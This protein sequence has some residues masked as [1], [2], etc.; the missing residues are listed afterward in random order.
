MQKNQPALRAKSRLLH[1][2]AVMSLGLILAASCKPKADRSMAGY[3][4]GANNDI[5]PADK[6]RASGSSI[7]DRVAHAAVLI[8][9]HL[10]EGKVKFCSGTLIAPEMASS[11]PRIL[12]NHHCFAITDSKGLA[13]ES[14]L[15]E[16]CV[17]TTIYFGVGTVAPGGELLKNSCAKGTL[18]THFG[19]DLA[20][21]NLTSAA[22]EG[23]SP[24]DIARK[25]PAN[26]QRGV[27]VHYP[28]VESNLTRL[29]G[30]RVSL[31]SASYTDKDCKIIGP[32]ANAE[33]KLDRSLAF[34]L[35]HTC[36]LLHGSSGSAIVN[37]DTLELVAV[38]WGGIKIRY[39]E[40]VETVN[41]ATDVMFVRA[42][43]A[44]QFEKLVAP[45]GA[46]STANDGRVL[47]ATDHSKS[48]KPK[49]RT[50]LGNLNCGTL[51]SNATSSHASNLLVGLL[52]FLLPVLMCWPLKRQL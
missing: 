47:E 9:T 7:P 21:F 18:R 39:G 6:A 10:D 17:K 19:A 35:K 34:S 28:D 52:I 45:R 43:L 36:D 24:L 3:I 22:P 46:E 37:A 42:F 48:E 51:T 12:T 14:L 23:F 32:F 27:V 25:S 50:G 38:N 41:A 2:F 16:S 11:M 20:V 33:F 8:A 4:I 26:G 29:A 15:P 1:H 31:P 49:S 44:E 30:E 40:K 13:T 5:I